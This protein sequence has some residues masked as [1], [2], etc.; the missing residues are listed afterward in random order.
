MRRAAYQFEDI[1]RPGK[2]NTLADGL[3]RSPAEWFEE[4]IA[5]HSSPTLLFV[6]LIDNAKSQLE[7][8]SCSNVLDLERSVVP[9][10]PHQE[11]FYLIK[12]N[13]FVPKSGSGQKAASGACCIQR[14][15]QYNPEP[16]IY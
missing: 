3:S 2:H 10:V 1:Y 7:D 9:Q 12:K 16:T 8:S 11:L 4:P 13:G 15:L 14:N 6:L 5:Y